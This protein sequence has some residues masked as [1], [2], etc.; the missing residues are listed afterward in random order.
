[1]KCLSTL[2]I[3]LLGVATACSAQHETVSRP[4][5][6]AA[7]MGPGAPAMSTAGSAAADAP[8]TTPGIPTTP[9]MKNLNN[10]DPPLRVQVSN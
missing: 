1:M 7:T 3:V 10:Y 5:P 4:A 2:A 9:T 6:A 8:V